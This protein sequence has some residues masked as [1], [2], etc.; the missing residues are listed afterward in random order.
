MIEIKQ[1]ITD[2]VLIV[3]K[4]E[5]LRYADLS[6]ANLSDAD[7]SDAN[8]RGADLSGA[9]LRGADLSGADLRGAKGFIQW[10]SPQGEKR[11]CCSVKHDKCIMHQ[12]GCFWG[13]TNEAIKAIRE[14]YGDDSMYEQLLALNAKALEI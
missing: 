11:I 10:Q 8:L 1:K 2:K 9:D 7:L 14:K 5:N 13:N 12:L 3:V 6:Y 4:S